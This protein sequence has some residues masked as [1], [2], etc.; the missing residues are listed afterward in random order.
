VLGNRDRVPAVTGPALG[1]QRRPVAPWNPPR[2]PLAIRNWFI[3]PPR[4]SRPPT[5]IH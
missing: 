2:N 5:A 3:L 4:D 1:Q